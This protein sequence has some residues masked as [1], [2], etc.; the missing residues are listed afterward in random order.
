V[1]ANSVLTDD[2][3]IKTYNVR[4]KL[5]LKACKGCRVHHNFIHT[6]HGLIN[7]ID[8][9]AKCHNLQKL[10]CKRDFAAGVYQSLW[11]GDTVSYVGIFDPAL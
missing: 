4:R 7:Y 1:R 3:K 9:K 11:I 8:T 5:L 2:T 10:T 6:E